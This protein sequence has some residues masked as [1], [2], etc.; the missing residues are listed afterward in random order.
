M[1]PL[2]VILVV[3]LLVFAVMG[4]KLVQQAETMV[5]ERLGRYHRTLDSGLHVIWPVIDKP[6]AINWRYLVTAPD[7]R[8]VFAHRTASGI[9]LNDSAS[10]AA[11]RT[12]PFGT[13]V[14]VT[15]LINGQSETVEITDRGPYIKGRIID[16]SHQAARKLG[17]MEAGIVPVEIEV[18]SKAPEPTPDSLAKD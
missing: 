4:M 13:V 7:G 10:T 3:F 16:V 2:L 15:N 6:R 18:Q 5:I 12:L 9:P 1:E 8:T 14:R 17:M 11:H